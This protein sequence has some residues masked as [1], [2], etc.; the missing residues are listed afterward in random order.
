VNSEPSKPM[1]SPLSATMST[2]PVARGLGVMAP[3]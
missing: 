1:S 2:A 3:D